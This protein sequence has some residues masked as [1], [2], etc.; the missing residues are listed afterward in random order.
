M[1]DQFISSA[2]A[3]DIP[4]T[5]ITTESLGVQEKFGL[6]KLIAKEDLV[7]SGSDVFTQCLEYID[8]QLKIHWHFKDKD[9]ILTGQILAQI[10][11]NLI[12]LIQAE[13]VA[14][15]F[16]GYLSGIATQT[17]LFVQR[18]EGTKTRILDT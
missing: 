13:R 4:T 5:D 8:P 11:G 17:Q 14:L 2:F 9:T 15:N 12:S 3:E 1:I 6:A 16:L 18:C 10:Q 7:L